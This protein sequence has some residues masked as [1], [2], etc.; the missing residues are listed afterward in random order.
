MV[1][2]E[3]TNFVSSLLKQEGAGKTGCAL[4]PRSRVHLML[5]KMRTRAYR[6]S[7][8]TPAFPAQWLYGLYA[9]LC[10]QNLAE[11]AN[12]RFSQNRPSL[13]LSPIVLEGHR[14]C[15][16]AWDRSGVF[17]NP[18]SCMG[19]EPEQSKE[20]SWMMAQNGLV[21]AGID[22]AKDKVDV[23][24]RSLSLKRTFANTVEDR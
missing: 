18:N 23:C 19:L 21:V 6:F 20:G 8:N 1:S 9:L 17:L 12:G 24:I 10:L 3:V 2:P 5:W 4:H 16:G 22:V 13:D 11:C 7:G 14:A 15:Q